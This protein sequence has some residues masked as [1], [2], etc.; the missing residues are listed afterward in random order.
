MSRKLGVLVAIPIKGRK[1]VNRSGGKQSPYIQL[2]L[3]DDKKRTKASLIAS[4]EPE[5]DQE[6][7]FDVFQNHLDLHVMVIDEGKKNEVIGDGILLLHEVI[8]KGE[9]DVWFPIK[10]KGSPA[11]DIYFELTFYAAAPPV[12]TGGSPMPP[13]VTHTPIRHTQPGFHVQGNPL[14]H[15]PFGPPAPFPGNTY[16]QPRPYSGPQLQPY[17]VPQPSVAT[18]PFRPPGPPGLAG[19]P[20]PSGGLGPSFPGFVPSAPPPFRPSTQYTSPQMAHSG[21]SNSYGSPRPI[22]GQGPGQGYQMP[23]PFPIGNSYPSGNMPPV[24][25]QPLPMNM[26]VPRPHGARPP[27]S[28]PNSAPNMPSYRPNNNLPRPSA[29]GPVTPLMQYN[30]SLGSFP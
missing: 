19:P 21:V 20:R 22:P 5:W 4:V 2:K 7:R 17:P 14:P 1:L 11:G 29:S 13:Q 16:Q 8:D 3:G 23:Q 15:P 30:Y 6:V 27:N 12:I 28:H 10:Y 26:P 24:P 25:S 9:L 18:G